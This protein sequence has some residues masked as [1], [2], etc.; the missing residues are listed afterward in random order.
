MQS[1]PSGCCAT[2]CH[3]Q[4]SR[5]PAALASV[6]RS[7]VV[8]KWQASG[9]QREPDTA[10]QSEG[11]MMGLVVSFGGD[12]EGVSSSANQMDLIS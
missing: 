7:A 3:V 10:A 12:G 9:A 4:A 8:Q 2:V 6:H 1:P 5:L 11:L